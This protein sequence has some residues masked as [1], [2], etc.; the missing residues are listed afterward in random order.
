MPSLDDASPAKRQR[1]MEMETL[2][3]HAGQQVASNRSFGAIMPPIYTATSFIQE[4]LGEGGEFCYSRVQNPTRHAYETAMA[5]LEGGE[6]CAATAS[7]LAAV[8]LALDLVAPGERV[9]AHDNVY[10]GTR[11][12]L[13]TVCK[14]RHGVHV[15]YVDL[16]QPDVLET[17]CNGVDGNK[18]RLVWAESPTNPLL[19]LLDLRQLAS[20]V[21]KVNFARPAAAS[22]VLLVVDN[23]F[24]T[25]FNQRPLEHGVDLVMVSSSKFIG[26][27][28]DMIGGAL[29]VTNKGNQHDLVEQVKQIHKAVGAIAS[30]FDCYMA[31]RGMKTLAVRME[32]QAETAL[33]IA[34]ALVGE[35]NLLEVHYPLLQDHRDHELCAKQM[36][37]GGCV[38]CI[39]LKEDTSATVPLN[40]TRGDN[41]TNA[42]SEAVRR[43]IGALQIFAL[44]ESLGGVE[45]TVN[46]SATMSHGS[47]SR[48]QRATLGI[49]DTTLRLSIGLEA[50]ADL[51]ADLRD[52]WKAM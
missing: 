8:K 40:E 47:M 23:T 19:Q 29:V 18:V 52:A 35:P 51:L 16:R 7:G 25:A 44:A 39:R 38:I 6:Y 30:P 49:F 41:G 33:K 27:H 17:A 32:R 11:R 5:D 31:L 34:T 13:D 45:S 50:S 37:T 42:S 36:R 28:S 46:H 9:L 12:L 43:F 4:N 48:E 20:V 24:A 1:C 22:K 14:A 10:G 2:C 3:I 15:D 26:G 21:R